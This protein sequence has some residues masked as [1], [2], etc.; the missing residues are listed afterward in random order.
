MLLVQVKAGSEGKSH[1]IKSSCG[2]KVDLSEIKTMSFF[3]RVLTMECKRALESE[4]T[5][6]YH[7]VFASRFHQLPKLAGSQTLELQNDSA[8]AAANKGEEPG[9]EPGLRTP[10]RRSRVKSLHEMPGPNTLYNLYEFF[11]KDGFGRIHEIQV[12]LTRLRN[13]VLTPGLPSAFLFAPRTRRS[14]TG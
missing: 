9:A 14:V 13:L 11:W 1:Q 2:S 5:Y 3:T 4:R 10:R 12:Q 8:A 7:A 6:F